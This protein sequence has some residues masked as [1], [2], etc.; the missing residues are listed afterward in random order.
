[1][2]RAGVTWA[3]AARRTAIAAAMA[4]DAPA[5]VRIDEEGEAIVARGRVP[6]WWRRSVALLARAAVR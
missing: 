3:M 4:A 2:M 1:M 5:G 6:G